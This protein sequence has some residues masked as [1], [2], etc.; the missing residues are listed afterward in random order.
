MLAN[1]KD[2]AMIGVTPQA[3]L[4]RVF[5]G[6][7]N[8]LCAFDPVAL[9]ASIAGHAERYEWP[10]FPVTIGDLITE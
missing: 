7:R 10:S 1:G 5:R 6:D 8:G 4:N 3:M 9:S 2:V